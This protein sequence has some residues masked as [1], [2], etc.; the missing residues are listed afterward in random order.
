MKQEMVQAS[1]GVRSDIG[2][3]TRS[4]EQAVGSAVGPLVERVAR[5]ICESEKM[6]PDDPLGGWRHWIDAANAAIRAMRRKGTYRQ[7]SPERV[8]LHERVWALV[9]RKFSYSEI[10]AQIGISRST[11]AGICFRARGRR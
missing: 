1:S 6:N 7:M 5:A 11:V 9:E 10:A 8:A 2:P 3:I 4:A